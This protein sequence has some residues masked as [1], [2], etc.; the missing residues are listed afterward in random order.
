MMAAPMIDDSREFAR[1]DCHYNRLGIPKSYMV[2]K[3]GTGGS[4]L[5]T[6]AALVEMGDCPRHILAL[7]S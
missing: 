1:L 2:V 5:G 4:Y 6:V 3:G 7:V